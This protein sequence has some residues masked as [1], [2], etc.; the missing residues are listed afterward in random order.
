MNNKKMGKNLMNFSLMVG[1]ATFL[2]AM[3]VTPNAL[4]QDAAPSAGSI[5]LEEIVV[6]ARKREESLQDVPISITAFDGEDIR[7]QGIQR[8]EYLAP[9]VPN[10][11]FSQ[12]PTGNDQFFM[13]GIGNGINFGFE[14][15]VGQVMDG[16]FYGRSRIGR[17]AFLD[18]ERVE[19]LKGPQGAILGKNNSGGAINLTT[20]KPTEEFEGAVTGSGNFD[21]NNGW[22]L[23]GYISGP[24][25]RS[26]K[27][28]IAFRYDAFDGYINNTALDT[29]EQSIKDITMRAA[30]V[31]HPLDNLAVT[32]SYQLVDF[33]RDGQPRELFGCGPVLI[34][35]LTVPGFVPECDLN[36]ETSVNGPV[37]GVPTQDSFAHK[38]DMLH[39]TINWEIGDATLTFLSG[40]MQYDY[41]DFFDGD[42]T[43]TENRS[44]GG[45]ENYKQQLE[46]L[47][48]SS[49]GARFDYTAG[50]FF[51][52][53]EQD[54]DFL[55]N[56]AARTPP[57]TRFIQSTQETATAAV[58]GEVTFHITNTVDMTLGARYTYET[59][60]LDQRQGPT[61]LYTRDRIT[62]SSGPASNV[63]DILLDRSEDNFSPT[64]DVLWR[65]NDNTM[66]Y[67]SVRRGFK[68]G[69]FD[70][71]L[72]APQASA[73]SRV[74]FD[75]EKAL[76]Y[77]VGT[78]LTLLNG[79]ARLNV[80]LFRTEFEGLQQSAFVSFGTFQ[81]G[82]AA[83]AR[84][85]GIE[86]GLDWQP[87]ERLII[88]ADAAYLNAEYTSYDNGPCFAK[89]VPATG[90]MTP[91]TGSKFQNLTGTRLPWAP[92]TSAALDATY[93]L[94]LSNSVKLT[95]FVQLIHSGS[96]FV[97]TDLDPNLTQ[98]SYQTLNLRIAIA[99][100]N[101][102]W[103]IAFVGRN[104]TDETI[105]TNGADTSPDSF[106]VFLQPPRV[107]GVQG[108]YRF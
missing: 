86:L 98:D 1:V 49:T 28:R 24:I 29:N 40:Y 79:S 5:V 91:A 74:E 42:S 15:S 57:A 90:C 80:A 67:G 85:Q 6:T 83:E 102:A 23:E 33:N 84:T 2:A 27:G 52:L 22:G 11:H 76:A 108:T 55:I 72:N 7:S 68:S 94:P 75:E 9:S 87:L 13:R 105:A 3:V 41:D 14:N 21:G 56:F 59:K 92:K 12:V 96:Y 93:T 71:L 97:A 31:W 18:L 10:F 100:A 48:F 46:E 70:M 19:V 58:F 63:H 77:E 26:L 62:V 30:L 60:E 17:A 81:V 66:F 88:H 47:R 73:L 89:Q 78:K 107:L 61:T 36:F 34:G 35:Q 50:V 103:E 16:F 95:G 20:A 4:A 82:N 106:T 104:L 45:I 69:G 99:G 43:P 51:L 65:P 54:S 101:D 25:T 39:L 32:A 37:N 53:A 8:L 38:Q 44:F 64:F